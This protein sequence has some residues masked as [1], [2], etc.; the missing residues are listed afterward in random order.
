MSAEREIEGFRDFS[1]RTYRTPGVPDACLSLQNDFGAD[2]NMVLYCC[3]IGAHV[4]EFGRE[5]FT[6]A[7]QFSTQWADQ[8]VV[9]LRS[10]RTWMKHS[11]CELETVPTNAC[12][13][14]RETIK[15]TEFASEKLQQQVLESLVSIKQLSNE[16]P[17]KFL[18]AVI[19]N[20][21]RYS[22]FAGIEV[23][24]DV[25]HKFSVITDAAFP[26]PVIS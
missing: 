22:A 5:I 26:T 18:D 9:S 20:L 4:G 1:V 7:C 6:E 14:L 25:R 23:C 11:G 13:E 17:D 12:M 2:V 19:A 24:D 10:A 16:A 15:S 8:V 3:W 21:N